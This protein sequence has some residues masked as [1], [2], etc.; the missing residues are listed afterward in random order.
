VLR[1]ELQ[2]GL[3]RQFGLSSGKVAMNCG[4]NLIVKSIELNDPRQS[5]GLSF[6]SPSKGH[7]AGAA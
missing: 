3:L 6:V 5:R 4:K 1:F 7:S 2:Q